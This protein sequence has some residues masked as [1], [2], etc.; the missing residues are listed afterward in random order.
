MNM[1]EEI[2]RKLELYAFGH[3]G[4]F[5]TED[6]VRVAVRFHPHSFS[7]AWMFAEEV[8]QKYG[9]DVELAVID[10]Q[11]L[12]TRQRAGSAAVLCRTETVR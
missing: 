6:R 4:R 11:D 10:R 5:D 9:I 7:L 12:R 2:R 1:P 8:F 3:G